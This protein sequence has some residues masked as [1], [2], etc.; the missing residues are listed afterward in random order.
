MLAGLSNL[1]IK[2]IFSIIKLFSSV[3]TAPFM[4]ILN[5]LLPNFSNFVGYANQFINQYLLHGIAFFREIIL[6]VTGFPRDLL[7]SLIAYVLARVSF[8]IAKRPIKFVI[9]KLRTIGVIHLGSGM[10]E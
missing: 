8:D 6:N 5:L 3:I 2:F 10:E 9:N 1:I 7:Q 4:L